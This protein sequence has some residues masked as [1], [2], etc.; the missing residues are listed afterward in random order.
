MT[1]GN[2]SLIKLKALSK[3]VANA[4]LQHDS[5]RLI[6]HNDADGLSA[7]GI[8]AMLFTGEA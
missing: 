4:I 3:T 1:D 6:S 8:C 5:V 7:A 2:D